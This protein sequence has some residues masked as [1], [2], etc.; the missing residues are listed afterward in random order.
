MTSKTGSHI[1][2]GALFESVRLNAELDPG[3][4]THLEE[5]DV[6]RGRRSW[7][8]AAT[9]LGP[10]EMTY[11]PPDAVMD[12]VLSLGRN[13][14]LERLR[15]FII[16]SLSFDSF[17]ALAPAGVRRAETTERHMTFEADDIEISLS[18][19][20]SDSRSFILTGQVLRKGGEP[21]TDTSGRV[22]LVIEGEHIATTTLSPWGEFMFQD[23]GR[24]SYALQLALSDRIL[25]IQPLP[26]AQ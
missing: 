25:R 7:M 14:G 6:C 17:N 20:P 10:N 15:K 4:R 16:A 8:E 19:R 21:V 11:D 26:I 12:K 2:T 24:D 18:F 9:R 13:R 23:L 22:A 5:C 1:A 3:A